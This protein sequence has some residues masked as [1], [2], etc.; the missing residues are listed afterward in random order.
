MMSPKQPWR[1]S[2]NHGSRLHARVYF[3]LVYEVIKPM[4]YNNLVQNRKATCN[5]HDN[6]FG[7]KPDE[8]QTVVEKAGLD[9]EYRDLLK[10]R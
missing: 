9:P 2:Q 7:G 10:T 1:Q 6:I 5:E 8:N 3:R 4:N